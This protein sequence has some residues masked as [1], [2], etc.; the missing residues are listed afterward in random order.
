M[1]IFSRYRKD[2]RQD[3]PKARDTNL[4]PKLY[5]IASSP[6]ISS[7]P[8]TSEWS[9]DLCI[10][11]PVANTPTSSIKGD[12]TPKTNALSNMLHHKKQDKIDKS[13]PETAEESVIITPDKHYYFSRLTPSSHSETQPD[14]TILRIF[15]TSFPSTVSAD[16]SHVGLTEQFEKAI[17]NVHLTADSSSWLRQALYALQV[18]EI[19]P[20]VSHG[21]DITKFMSFSTSYLEQHI[22]EAASTAGHSE[23]KEVNYSKILRENE[24]L[25]QMFSSDTTD[26]A[27]MN[28]ANE[29]SDELGHDED[30][31]NL[32]VRGKPAKAEKHW[33]G[34]WVTHGSEGTSRSVNDDRRGDSSGSRRNVYGGLM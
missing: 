33:G 26:Y 15:L 29:K 2:H 16:S 20:P 1:S 13:L 27:V 9:F 11:A 24:R 6:S 18:A 32:P 7:R 30:V 22:R 5:V 28:T 4:R 25:R 31:W 14:N 34:F 23:V 10:P 12:E 17:E 3:S 21:L 8:E 19:I